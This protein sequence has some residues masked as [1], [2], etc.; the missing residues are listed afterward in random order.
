VSPS[1]VTAVVPT[2]TGFESLSLADPAC[3]NGI[4]PGGPYGLLVAD[5]EGAVGEVPASAGFT[6][7]TE[8]PPSITSIT[9]GSTETGGLTAANPLVVT[10]TGFGA[11]AKVQ[12]LSQL[13]S[14]NVLACDL[15]AT[16]TPSATELRALVPGS[17]PAASCV[18]YTPAGTQVEGPNTQAL[19]LDPGLYVVRVQNTANPAFA[20]YSGL[21]VTTAAANPLEGPLFSTRLATPRASFPLVTATDDLGQTFMYALGGMTRLVV[22]GSG[23]LGPLASVEVAQVTLFGELAGECSGTSCTFRTLASTPLGVGRH[24]AENGT[25]FTNTTPVPRAGHT[26]VV[27]TVRGDTSYIFLMG[28]ADESSTA[29]RIVERAQVLRVADAP[30]LDTPTLTTQEANALP[31]GT[32]YYRVSAVLREDHPKNPGGETLPSDEYSVKSLVPTTVAELAWPCQP[33][34]VRYRV[35]RTAT[36]NQRAGT[37]VLLEE[38]AAPAC[39]GTPL[40]QVTY[41]DTGTVQPAQDA[42]RPLPPGALGRWV[43][44]ARGLWVERGQAAATLVGDD[45]YITGGFCSTPSADCP[46][47]LSTLASTERATLVDDAA[48]GPRPGGFAL[49][50][51]MNTARMR[52]SVAVASAATAPASFASTSPDNRQDVWLLVV[53]GDQGAAPISSST[54]VEVSRVRDIN[55]TVANNTFT[56]IDNRNNA[57]H[58]GW[59]YVAA[60]GFF[61]GGADGTNPVIRSDYLCKQGSTPVACTGPGSFPTSLNSVGGAGAYQ[62]GEAR[63][64]AGSTLFRAFIYVAGGFPSDSSISGLTP[65]STVESLLY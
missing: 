27:R 58:G 1:E 53:G 59:A 42:P 17:I 51:S 61:L 15:P 38:F 6:V 48:T 11:G 60:N 16:G 44:F 8:E 26:A 14:G 4:V 49:G 63:Y 5:V 52:H 13:A 29:L 25:G 56:G 9:P 12:L 34:A 43:R 33:D 46:G 10:G 35:Y 41:R 3:P 28:G 40:P 54:T 22:N 7:L 55:G 30:A 32:F 50:A 37:E 45:I 24:L 65:S 2:C 23:R 31:V 21:V 19:R 36:A 39:S 57:H 62:E 20:N 18:Q 47:T 64:L